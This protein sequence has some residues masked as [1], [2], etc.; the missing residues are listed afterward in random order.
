MLGERGGE[1]ARQH[2]V[3][4]REGRGGACGFV[5]FAGPANGRHDHR[6]PS[7]RARA[8]TH[9]QTLLGVRF[10]KRAHARTNT[11]AHRAPGWFAAGWQCRGEPSSHCAPPSRLGDGLIG[12]R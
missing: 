1:A 7:A 8:S 4:Q 6:Q 3:V 5:V 10:Q 9:T 2:N 12:G 11:L